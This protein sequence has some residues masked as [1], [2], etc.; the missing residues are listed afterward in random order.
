MSVA[1]C[2]PDGAEPFREMK[3]YVPEHE[4][5]QIGSMS[6][7]AAAPTEPTLN[8]VIVFADMFGVHT[9]RHKQLVD[10]LAHHGYLAVCPDFLRERPYMRGSTPN[11]GMNYCCAAEFLVKMLTG[12]FDRNTRTFAWDTFM[13]KKVVDEIMPWLNAKGAKNLAAIGFCW[14]T[15]GAMK[16]GSLPQFKCCVG[17]HPSTEGFCKAAKEDD[18]KVCKDV[19]CPQL[20]IVTKNESERWK[21]DGAAHKACE[22][23]LAGLPGTVLWELQDGMMHGY[24]TR[25]DTQKVETMQAV[26]YG[27]DSM[28]G[29]FRENLG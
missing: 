28:I 3:D 26:Q 19:K 11:F 10:M 14:G 5:V 12:A 21:P 17:F 18:L 22:E 20:M 24:M 8:A 7:Y 15:Y 4:M 1:K 27:F 16:C 29:F 9:G 25:G 2:C 13:R 6:C 23:A